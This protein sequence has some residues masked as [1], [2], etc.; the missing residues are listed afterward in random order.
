M[1]TLTPD[2]LFS[3]S[4]LCLVPSFLQISFPHPLFFVLFGYPLSL[5][6]AICMTTALELFIEAWWACWGWGGA[7]TQLKTVTV[8]LHNFIGNQLVQQ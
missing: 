3:F 8:S 5:S 7:L 6:K 4:N 2:S 1:V